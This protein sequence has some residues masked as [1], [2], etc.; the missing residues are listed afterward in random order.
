MNIV[1]ENKLENTNDLEKVNKTLDW[2]ID[3][4]KS[5]DLDAILSNIQNEQKD[6]TFEVSLI[7][8]C[9]CKEKIKHGTITNPA[10]KDGQE[11]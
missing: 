8:N 2:H 7:D 1:E 11:M 3:V 4:T 9:I 6:D 10:Y 5:Q